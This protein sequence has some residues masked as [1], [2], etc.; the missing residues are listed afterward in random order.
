MLILKTASNESCLEFSYQKLGG[1]ISLSTPG[2]KAGSSE[3][4][5]TYFG[6]FV[7]DLP[8]PSQKSVHCTSLLFAQFGRMHCQ[9]EDALLSLCRI[10]SWVHDCEPSIRVQLAYWDLNLE[11]QMLAALCVIITSE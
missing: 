1:N 5:A 9:S 6:C 7:I 3:D 8:C 10:L 2:V 11:F 4:G